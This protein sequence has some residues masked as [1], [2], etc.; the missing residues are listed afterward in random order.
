MPRRTLFEAPSLSQGRPQSEV[1]ARFQG[2]GLII[3]SDGGAARGALNR[4]RA[5]HTTAFLGEMTRLMRSV[6]WV[7]PMPAERWTGTTAAAIDTTGGVSSFPLE[8]A[9]MIRA[10]DVLRGTRAN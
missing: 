2:A 1:L 8:A 4:I 9:A 10:V 5:R 3:V 7:N 6:V